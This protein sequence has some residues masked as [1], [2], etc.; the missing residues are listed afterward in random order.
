MSQ[1]SI[2]DIPSYRAALI[3][4]A[5]DGFENFKADPDFQFA[6]EHLTHQQGKAYADTLTLISRDAEHLARVMQVAKMNDRLGNP[7]RYSYGWTGT[8]SPTSLRYAKVA[9]DLHNLFGDLSG[10]RIVEIGGGYGGQAFILGRLYPLCHYSMFD[11]S[12]ALNLQRR[13]L[14][15]MHM[16]TLSY[17][18]FGNCEE[19]VDLV[20]SNYAIT[21]CTREVQQTAIEHVLKDAKRGYLTCNEISKGAGIDSMSKEELKS[22]L[23]RAVELPEKPLTHPDNYL[24]VWK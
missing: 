2:S 18:S 9:V 4:A 5:G 19:P 11:L 7:T 6:L 8:I 13:Y 1:T 12:E 17:F 15:E 21:E 24:L 10:M 20:I 14:R 23:P 16:P 3:R 22:S